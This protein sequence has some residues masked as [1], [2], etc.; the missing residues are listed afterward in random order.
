MLTRRRLYPWVAILLVAGFCFGLARLLVL[1]YSRGDAFPAYSSLRADPLGTK[2][3]HESLRALP[4]HEVRRNERP[5]TRLG[6]G[7]G[8][9]LLLL[10]YAGSYLPH[11]TRD[12]LERFV[13]TGGRL[14]VAMYPRHASSRGEGR[15]P[16]PSPTPAK[17]AEPTPTPRGS[18]W[19]EVLQRWD[20]A[21]ERAGAEKDMVA[22]RAGGELPIEEHLS[23]HS[24]LFFE[25]KH[26]DWQIIYESELGPV[27][28]ERA[29]GRGSVVLA[30]DSYFVSNEALLVERAPA[31]LV[32]L[33]GANRTVIFDESHL[34]V[35]EDPGVAALLRRYGLTGFVAGFLLLLGLWL[36]RNATFALAPRPAHARLEAEPAVSGRDSFSGFVRLLR[37]G[38]APAQLLPT[39]LAEWKKTAS[40]GERIQLDEVALESADPVTAYNTLSARFSKKWKTK[41]AS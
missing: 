28:L 4:E 2:V 39:C 24:G 12:A 17:E 26:P 21:L 10:G 14:V 20:V 5:L 19:E 34:N 9:T 18:K 1:R 11:K 22:V 7:A 6:E 37:R 38:I 32:W 40:A 30:G 35:R 13:Q 16:T 15:S 33:L 8:Q 27:V 3:L 36:W 23:W 41:P 31:L 29:F 25:P